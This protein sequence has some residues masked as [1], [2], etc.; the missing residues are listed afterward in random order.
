LNSRGKTAIFRTAE[1]KMEV[2]T[3]FPRYSPTGVSNSAT[4]TKHQPS[5]EVKHFVSP[6]PPTP[7]ANTTGADPENHHPNHPAASSSGGSSSAS[8]SSF[9]FS[10][11]PRGG[12][13]IR[14]NLVPLQTPVVG[15]KQASNTL[16]V[17][18]A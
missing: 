15:K 14:S 16:N 9:F 10:F 6:N 12:G 4:I 11:S 3:S 7:A 5:F 2:R 18:F 17:L 13:G 8:S 1:K